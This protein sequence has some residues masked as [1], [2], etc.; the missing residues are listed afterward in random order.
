MPGHGEAAEEVS[1]MTSQGPLVRTAKRVVPAPVRDAIR[2]LLAPGPP[3][4]SCVVDIELPA[5]SRRSGIVESDWFDRLYGAAPDPWQFA[6][7][8]YERAKYEHMLA[9]LPDARYGRALEIGC[10]IGVFTERLAARC[11]EV[12]G[13][14]I[15]AAA[16]ELANARLESVRNA[17]AV[18]CRVPDEMP[19]GTFDLI[20]VG[21]VMFY[22]DESNCRAAAE[23]FC[24]ALDPRGVLLALHWR[25][26]RECEVGGDEAHD[27]LCSD[28]RLEHV[29][30][31]RTA[32]YRLDVW[33][34]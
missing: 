11:D 26:A 9:A 5:V 27:I 18:V 29:S 4:P 30:D 34:A 8:S 16:V 17:R 12:L 1:A 28:L 10:S 14:D 13:V 15:S 22:W 19:A 25:V 6:S 23:R 20:V 31:Q 33:R 32:Q 3:G 21:D 24:A 2:A 7:N